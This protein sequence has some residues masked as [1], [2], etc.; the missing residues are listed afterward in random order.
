MTRGTG[1]PRPS[2]VFGGGLRGA[3]F[4]LGALVL[5]LLV[6]GC[7]E[8][9]L[10][11]AEGRADGAKVYAAYCVGCH[12]KDRQRGPERMHLTR[13]PQQPRANVLKIVEGGSR[14]MPAWGKRL[15]REQIDAV[16]DYLYSR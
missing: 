4:V 7:G 1:M 14:D 5:G 15:P 2:G 13:V 3:I 12:G 8:P 6:G 10:R 11:G 16:V 9:D